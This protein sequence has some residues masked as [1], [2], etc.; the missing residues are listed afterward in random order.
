MDRESLL[1]LHCEGVKESPGGI[2]R[3]LQALI[4]I[5]GARQPGDIV[6][7]GDR[8][9]EIGMSAGA[10]EVLQEVRDEQNNMRRL[11]AEFLLT[12]GD[13]ERTAEDFQRFLVEVKDSAREFAV[14]QRINFEKFW[15]QLMKTVTDAF[16]NK[17][18]SPLGETD[19]LQTQLGK[20]GSFAQEP[21]EKMVPAL[22]EQYKG[23]M[24]DAMT[25]ATT[26]FSEI[27]GK[28]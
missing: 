6:S 22:V 26:Y 5:E 20:L 13:Q 7:I 10:V 15:R 28:E 25:A 14:K 19:E 21:R 8:I 9:Q 12:M 24:Q 3:G 18:C 11:V 27:L 23:K 4:R 17:A 2:A 16:V 1:R